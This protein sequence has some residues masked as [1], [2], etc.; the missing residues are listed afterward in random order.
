[1]NAPQTAPPGFRN[2]IVGHGD[3]DP[4]QLLSNPKNY[5]I[6]PK[7][8]QTALLAVLDR[9][10]WVSQVMVNRRTGFVVDGHSRV[11]LALRREEKSVPVTYLDL[12]DEEEA[13]ILATFDQTTGMAATDAAKLR[14]LLDTISSEGDEVRELLDTIAEREKLD[15]PRRGAPAEEDPDWEAPPLPEVARTKFGQRW[16]LGR[17]T[18]MCGDTTNTADVA[19]LIGGRRAAAVITDPPYAIYGSSTGIA[20]DITDDKMVRP[21]FRDVVRACVQVLQPFGHAY[22]CCDWRSYPSWWEV[23][24]GSGLIPKNLIVWAKDGGLGS[25][26]ANGHE[27]LLFASHRPMRENMTQKIS[28]ERM[29]ND[30]NVWEM[31]RVKSSAGEQREHNAQKPVALFAR[32]MNNSSD[33]G[34]LVV[35]FFGGSGTLAIAAE[36]E[37][38]EA[39]LME[40]DPRWCDVIMDRFERVTG[41]PAE[42]LED[43]PEAAPAE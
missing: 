35:D 36:Q 28:G 43:T 17:H 37:G 31:G 10:G 6:H 32:A 18:L 15:M 1:M 12:S 14:E 27:F 29:V 33:R 40:I 7:E 41:I 20:S 8:Q 30:M 3:A 42:L 34:D 11:L 2:R 38:R 25:M 19:R 13:I 5:R 4:A 39:A 16:K 23:A 9:V 24:K 21:F 26:Y 22:V